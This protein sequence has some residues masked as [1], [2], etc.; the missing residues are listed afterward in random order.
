MDREFNLVTPR[1]VLSPLSPEHTSDLALV[2]ADPDVA[3]YVGGDRCLGAALQ[4]LP[5]APRIGLRNGSHLQS[6]NV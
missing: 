4:A 1:L 6:F 2:C 5:I 3:R